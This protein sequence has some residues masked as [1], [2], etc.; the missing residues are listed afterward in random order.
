MYTLTI[1]FFDLPSYSSESK[2]RY[3]LKLLLIYLWKD[4]DGV[5]DVVLSGVE[6]QIVREK[7]LPGG[8]RG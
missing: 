6:K 8:T 3:K 1:G 2:K 7:D 4:L 5:L